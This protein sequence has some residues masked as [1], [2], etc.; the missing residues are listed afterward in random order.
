MARPRLAALTLLCLTGLATVA[1]VAGAPPPTTLC[2]SCADGV[3]GATESGTLDVYID[4]DGDSRWVERVPVNDSAAD[5]YRENA[6]ALEHEVDPT[7]TYYHRVDED[8][9][10]TIALE[11]GTVTVTYDVENVARP[12][13]RDAW[14]VDYFV[15]DGPHRYGL[16]AERV[17]I[18]APNGTVV[19][20]APSGA[21]VDGNAATWT[22]TSEFGDSTYVTYGP[23]DTRGLVGTANSYAT[24]G[25]EVG[26]GALAGGVLLGIV[27]GLVLAVGLLV[28]GRVDWG[29]DA[30]D[31]AELERIPILLGA[32]GAGGLLLVSVAIV[33]DRRFA[34][35]PLALGTLGLG[36]ALLGAVGRRWWR[37]FGPAGVSA[38]PALATVGTGALMTLV[39]GPT[40]FVAVLPFG[41]VAALYL[42]LGCTAGRETRSVTLLAGA[43]GAPIV[44]L[45]ALSLSDTLPWVTV[46]VAVGYPLVVLGARA[47]ETS[48]EHG[49]ILVGLGSVAVL[50]PAVAFALRSSSGGGGFV[51][52]LFWVLLSLGA[53]AVAIFGY[54]LSLLGRRLAEERPRY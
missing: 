42:P 13:V 1:V 39:V 52:V 30:F 43:V 45:A 38:L 20:N 2:G 41:F 17:T 6:T 29:R 49:S 14:L 54:P 12:G 37:R 23:S 3:P 36:Y 28:V 9:E 44:A 5:R 21:N 19:T 32:I 34:P 7:G 18:H 11:N 10:R 48:F 47:V 40:P 4:A 51:L 46:A 26:P 53:V 24:L 50:V 31:T 35:G 25:L 15:L 33:A 22:D 16:A 8:V 27:P